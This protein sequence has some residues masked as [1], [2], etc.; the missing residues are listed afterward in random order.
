M[1]APHWWQKAVIYQIYPRSFQDSDG[2]G[3]GDLRGILARARLLRLARHRGAL[4]L[5]DLSLAD[6][7]LR[8]RRRRL[9]RHRSAVRHACGLRSPG[10]GA[11]RAGHPP[12]P[13]LRAEPHLG[14]ASLVPGGA[15]S[16]REPE[17][18][19]VHLAR[20]GAGRRAAQQLGEP[21]GRQRLGARPGE[22]PVLLPRL[23][24]PA[25]G[26]QLAQSRRARGDVRRAPLLAR[27]RRRR[28]PGRRLLAHDQGR[29]VPRRP[30]QSGLSRGRAGFP[31]RAAAPQRRSARGARD[32]DRD[33]A[34]ARGISGRSPAD[35][36]DLP[37][38]AAP[39]CLLR[40]RP[41]RACT[42]RSTSI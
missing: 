16:A 40:S 27:A 1:S 5:A 12:D 25:A 36:R 41:E 19:L 31:P 9:R 20:P 42:C 33:A 17:A 23:P 22:R 15:G 18:R 14:A 37:A 38:G 8:L 2:D 3:V 24:R 7:R 29:R 32:R 10:R 30:A 35:R 28:L 4:D 13:R 26:S 34:R 39:R 21:G 6:G 11:A